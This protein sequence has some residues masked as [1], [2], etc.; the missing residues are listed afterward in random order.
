M[1]VLIACVAAGAAGGLIA[2]LHAVLSV[3]FRANQI[4][5][6]MAINLVALGVTSLLLI[7]AFPNGSFPAQYATMPQIRFAVPEGT[8]LLSGINQAEWTW[9]VPIALVCVVGMHFFIFN[10][11]MGLRRSDP[12]ASIPWRPRRSAST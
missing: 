4:I 11:K 8:F 3:T 5:S 10:T 7:S 6:G 12:S 1:V 2:L 9:F